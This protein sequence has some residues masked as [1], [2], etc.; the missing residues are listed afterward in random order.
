[1]KHLL[2]LVAAIPLAA[3]SPAAKK[4]DEVARIASVMLDGDAAR[5]IQT[6]R[7][8]AMM[9]DPKPVEPWAASDNYEVNHREFI[10]MKKQLIRLA[11]LCELPCELNLWMPVATKPARIQVVIRNVL[12]MSQFW[13]WGALNQPMPAEMKQV[14]ETGKRVTVSRTPRVI[15]VLAPVFDSLGDVAGIVEVVARDRVDPQENVQ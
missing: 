2:W 10:A 12:E 6:P 3:Q 8:L 9:L 15:S 7:S 14:L 4:L 13:P 1:M 5:H 11:R